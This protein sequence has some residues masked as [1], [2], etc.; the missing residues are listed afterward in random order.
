MKYLLSQSDIFSHFG[1][2]KEYKEQKQRKETKSEG[3]RSRRTEREADEMDE[4][5]LA[6]AHEIG[7]GEDSE[8]DVDNAQTVLLKQPSIITGG[9]LR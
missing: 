3:K 2:G 1:V 6:M 8:G 5:E 7:E 9:Q 4:D